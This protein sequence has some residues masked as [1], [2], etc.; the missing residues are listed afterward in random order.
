MSDHDHRVVAEAEPGGDLLENVRPL[1]GLPQTSRA[2]RLADAARAG[3]LS[4]AEVAPGGCGPES[5]S[6]GDVRWRLTDVAVKA[7]GLGGYVVELRFAAPAGT[8]ADLRHAIGRHV[9][10]AADDRGLGPY[11][12]LVTIVV[13][14]SRA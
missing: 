10:E 8:D 5:T 11:L 6:D 7:S 4:L 14:G 2:R 13:E 3:A 1:A 12:E 9:R